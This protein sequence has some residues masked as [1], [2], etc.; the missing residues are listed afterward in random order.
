MR[1]ELNKHF[2]ARKYRPLKYSAL[3]IVGIAI[4]A[5]FAMII[6]IDDIPP[7]TMLFVRGCVGVCALIFVIL[8]AIL[9]Y[10]VYSEYFRNQ[11]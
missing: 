2:N 8:V 6:W 4:A 9:T 5:L 3:A 11:G 1:D 10:R 7:R